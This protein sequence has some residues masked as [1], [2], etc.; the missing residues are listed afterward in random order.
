MTGLTALSLHVASQAASVYQD[1]NAII[2]SHDGDIRRIN[3]PY[4]LR[5]TGSFQLVLDKR[6]NAFQ[7]ASS[8]A[9]GGGGNGSG[10]GAG[11]Q[12][13]V[14]SN[15][16]N[17]PQAPKEPPPIDSILVQ[18]DRLYNEGKYEEA[19]SLLDQAEKQS[20][21]NPQLLSMKG[22]LYYVMDWKESAAR[23]WQKSV[24]IN[25]NQPDVQ[26]H[27]NQLRGELGERFPA[28]QP[29]PAQPEASG[30]G[31]F[32]KNPKQA[33]DTGATPPQKPEAQV[34]EPAPQGDQR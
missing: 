25:P 10:G 18:A 14:S 28:H 20:P 3:L 15:P 5:Q 13:T 27:I 34:L 29:P 4:E 30:A 31:I 7:P 2:V 8:G 23:Y 6:R 22:S 26:E 17:P 33:L 1:Q 16:S 24:A 32:S 12:N 19:L 11:A 9:S 21:Q